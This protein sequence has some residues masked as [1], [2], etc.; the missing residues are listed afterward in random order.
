VTAMA[1][2]TEE[3][4][5]WAAKFRAE[6]APTMSDVFDGGAAFREREKAYV[7]TR[8]QREQDAIAAQRA[9]V[10]ALRATEKALVEAYDEFGATLEAFT[11]HVAG[12]S[13]LRHTYEQHWRA[14]RSLGVDPL[15]ARLESVPIQANA[16]TP[17]GLAMRQ[18]INRYRVATA[19][20]LP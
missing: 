4:E 5:A 12:I 10:K 14:V 1:Y 17:E 8:D 19:T 3:Q 13:S 9:A 11:Q 7:Q 16:D 20:P 6:H 18:L 2:E 15:P